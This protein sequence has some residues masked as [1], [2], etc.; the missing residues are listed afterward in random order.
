MKF[1]YKKNWNAFTLIEVLTVISIIAILAGLVLSTAGYIQRKAALARAQSE[2]KAIEAACE[3]Y[4]ADNGFYPIGKGTAGSTATDLLCPGGGSPNYNPI[5]S[6]NGSYQSACAVL[7]QALTGDGNDQLT[8]TNATSSIGKLGSSG[9]GVRIY[10]ELKP[11]QTG[12][13]GTQY[14]IVDPFGFSYGYSTVQATTGTNGYNPTFD[15]WSTAGTTGSTSSS[16]N[17]QAKWITNW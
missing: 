4:K 8:D 1:S 11:G 3:S 15:L 13:N 5:T 14:Y 7:Y 6:G 17:V 2:I 12:S 10:M 16:S 9:T